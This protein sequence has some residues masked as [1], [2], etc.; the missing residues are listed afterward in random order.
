MA[1][2]LSQATNSASRCLRLLWLISWSLGR[3]CVSAHIEDC[4]SR[5]VLVCDVLKKVRL[6]VSGLHPHL[7]N[8]RELHNDSHWGCG[9]LCKRQQ[10]GYECS[11]F[12]LGIA[13][14]FCEAPNRCSWPRDWVRTHRPKTHCVG[15]GSIQCECPALV[16]VWPHAWRSCQ[17]PC[18]WY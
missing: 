14:D 4:H 9:M 2:A 1:L 10:T 13:R 17:V 7:P 18:P 11:G 3:A 16:L 12:G 15:W 6:S 8:C 5:K